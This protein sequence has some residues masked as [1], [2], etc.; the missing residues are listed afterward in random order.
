MRGLVLAALLAT[1]AATPR[2]ER[3]RQL[4]KQ[5]S[6]LQLPKQQSSLQAPP[7]PPVQHYSCIN[8]GTQCAVDPTGTYTDPTCDGKVRAPAH[9]LSV[10][11]RFCVLLAR[12]MR[13]KAMVFFFLTLLP[14]PATHASQCGAKPGPP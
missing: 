1:A 13:G 3:W 2:P 8:L 6:S 4:P 11:A 5:Q 14:P 7:P 10:R 12:C 9:L